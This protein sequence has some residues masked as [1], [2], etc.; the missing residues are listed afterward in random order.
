VNAINN[1]N[2]KAEKLEE[3]PSFLK[4]L[5]SLYSGPKLSDTTQLS[6][7]SLHPAFGQALEQAAQGSGGVTIPGG[8]KS[9]LNYT[10]GMT[11]RGESGTG[12]FFSIPYNDLF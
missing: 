7:Q 10:Y 9:L 2:K 3:N 4:L 6:C 12:S 8:V 5:E 1:D 11:C